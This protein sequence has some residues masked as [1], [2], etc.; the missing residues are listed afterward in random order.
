[1]K[2]KIKQP[3]MLAKFQIQHLP[4]DLENLNITPTKQTQTHNHPNSDGYNIVTVD[5]VSSN[6]DENIQPENIKKD[7]DILGV[8]GT[9]A[10]PSGTINITENGTIDVGEYAIADV[11]VGGGPE[12]YFVSSI[13]S[14][15]IVSL[16]KK[17]P[18][19]TITN[20]I[21][22]SMSASGNLIEIEELN[23]PN[24]TSLGYT[25]SGCS[26]MES[27]KLITTSTL[28]N[29][30]NTFYNCSKLSEINLFNTENVTTME[31]CFRGCESLVTIPQYNTKKVSSFKRFAYV[32][33]NLENFP[34]LDFSSATDL[35]EMF[36]DCGKLTDTSLNNILLSCISATSYTGTKTLT[37]LGIY[38]YRYPASRIQALPN[39]QD[40]LNAGWTIGY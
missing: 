26:N 23:L 15:T 9:L 40:F 14:S 16:I 27:V 38:S 21:V 33:S 37:Q 4:T 2:V 31:Q 19:A 11:H 17:L 28:T 32:C 20:S 34:Q 1:M 7:I 24:I 6:V 13:A 3:K 22:T 29:L 25:F 12:D 8:V 10:Q 30:S 35:S 18:P 36:A 39:Y 5:A